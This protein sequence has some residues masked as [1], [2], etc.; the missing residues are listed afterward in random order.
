MLLGFIGDP[1]FS[2]LILHFR[3]RFR[4]FIADSDNMTCSEPEPVYQSLEDTSN[5]LRKRYF[6]EYIF[7][8]KEAVVDAVNDLCDDPYGKKPDV[9]SPEKNPDLIRSQTSRTIRSRST[10]LNEEAAILKLS[11]SDAKRLTSF[12]EEKFDRKVIPLPDIDENQNCAVSS[13][14]VQIGNQNFIQNRDGDLFGSSCFRDQIVYQMAKVNPEEI[15][16]RCKIHLTESYKDLLLRNLNNDEEGD[17]A[18]LIGARDLLE[19]RIW[20][21]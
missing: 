21:P 14:L 5:F 10:D 2:Y 6:T 7:L 15:Y 1:A 11:K 9:P 8:R 12:L 13:V 4:R 18:I 20:H 17:F 19:V 16:Q 3:T